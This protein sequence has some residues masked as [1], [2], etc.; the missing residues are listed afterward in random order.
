[1]N[2][3]NLSFTAGVACACRNAFLMNA[4][5]SPSH[6]PSRQA[7]SSRQPSAMDIQGGEEHRGDRQEVFIQ[8]VGFADCLGIRVQGCRWEGTH[9]RNEHTLAEH[10]QLTS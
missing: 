6:M 10:Q 5:S 9:A 3:P 7:S 1:M 8:Q 2:L 4:L